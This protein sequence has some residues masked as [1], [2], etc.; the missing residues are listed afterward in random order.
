MNKENNLKGTLN[1]LHEEWLSQMESTIWGHGEIRN[2]VQVEILGMKMLKAMERD[3]PAE[4]LGE[5]LPELIKEIAKAGLQGGLTPRETAMIIF[6]FR[7]FLNRLNYKGSAE[8]L[9]QI[10]DEMGILVLEFFF[11]SSDNIIHTQRQDLLELSTP[12]IKL[13]EGILALPLIGTLDSKRTQE[14]MEKLL[15]AIVNQGSKVIILD[16]TGV[17]TVDTLV[18]N[19]ILKTAAAVNLLGAKLIITGISPE[20]AQ[21][22]VHLGVDLGGIVTRAVMADGVELALSLLKMKIINLNKE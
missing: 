15:N 20:I 21:T 12:I 18:A 3:I 14:V 1:D 17:S 19:Y 5:E 11:E 7:P 2:I 10:L 8:R 4:G 6:S 13:W 16:I 22:M 9:N